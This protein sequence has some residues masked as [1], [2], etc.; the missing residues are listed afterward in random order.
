L[1]RSGNVLSDSDSIS[2][3]KYSASVKSS[4]RLF[5]GKRVEEFLIGDEKSLYEEAPP[6]PTKTVAEGHTL[7]HDQFGTLIDHMYR[8]PTV[9]SAS[10]VEMIDNQMNSL[11]KPGSPIRKDIDSHGA[12]L[13]DPTAKTATNNIH[14]SL[15][16]TE[17]Q[18]EER[19]S[20]LSMLSS[21][22]EPT[23]DVQYL[24][25]YGTCVSYIL[26]VWTEIPDYD[27]VE[28]L[29][30]LSRLEGS[31]HRA[32]TLRST[33]GMEATETNRVVVNGSELDRSVVVSELQSLG[34]TV[35]EAIALLKR[36]ANMDDDILQHRLS[37]P[38]NERDLALPA[39]ENQ[40]DAKL[41]TQSLQRQNT[42]P[43]LTW[44][45][46]SS[47]FE[48]SIPA[49]RLAAE[50]LFTIMQDI[51]RH[52]CRSNDFYMRAPQAT[53]T[54]LTSKI[55]ASRHKSRVSSYIGQISGPFPTDVKAGLHAVNELLSPHKQGPESPSA[56]DAILQS[57]KDA[58]VA[59]V[60]DIIE[61]AQKFVAL[62]IPCTYQHPV[63]K[64]I[65]GSL[66]GLLRV[67]TIFFCDR[68]HGDTEC[69]LV[70]QLT[71]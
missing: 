10:E 38:T 22:T 2:D 66:S 42:P 45:W 57:Q 64:K 63:S 11:S 32:E 43:F 28:H 44:A 12:N 39:S 14:T 18:L 6:S 46:L 33:C 60:N 1:D 58:T 19:D 50:N 41:R 51:D 24:E 48:K 17:D 68:H 65:W 37:S 49:R 3:K 9:E 26:H 62:F 53:I 27:K 30:I 13:P 69:L 16:Y 23:L 20:L 55:A 40:T 29:D 56:N 4:I 36:T 31:L 5:D 15:E 7:S 59:V 34:A 52:L 21:L 54:E 25:A 71:Q 8:E 61:T 35:Q 47:G 67:S 70:R